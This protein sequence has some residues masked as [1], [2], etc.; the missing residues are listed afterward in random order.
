MLQGYDESGRPRYKQYEGKDALSRRDTAFLEKL[1][2]TY[3]ARLFLM[4]N[5]SATKNISSF[6]KSALSFENIPR[7]LIF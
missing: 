4:E 1:Q 6:S 5:I 3:H 7:M 2:K